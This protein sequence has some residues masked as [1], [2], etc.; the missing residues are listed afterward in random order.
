MYFRSLF[1]SYLTRWNFR[2]IF[3]CMKICANYMIKFPNASSLFTNVLGIFLSQ[4]NRFLT[5]CVH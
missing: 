1:Y 3:W 4:E 2:F 5:L